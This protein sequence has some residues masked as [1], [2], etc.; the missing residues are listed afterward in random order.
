MSDSLSPD[1]RN[2]LP[3]E[4]N[5]QG[6]RTPTQGFLHDD[7]GNPEGGLQPDTGESGRE[8]GPATPERIHGDRV[9]SQG[10]A[11]AADSGDAPPELASDDR[12]LLTGNPTGTKPM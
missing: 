8:P 2:P 6:E 7:M 1:N 4:E 5:P 3:D 10:G 11:T 12:S 9:R